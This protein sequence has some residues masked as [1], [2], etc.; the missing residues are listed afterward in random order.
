MMELRF[1]ERTVPLTIN[2]DN[3]AERRRILQYR[4]QV[5]QMGMGY[6]SGPSGIIHEYERPQGW[7]WTE[8]QDVPVVVEP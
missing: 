1:V 6:H 3:I 2:G 7:T 4:T 5:M 8:W